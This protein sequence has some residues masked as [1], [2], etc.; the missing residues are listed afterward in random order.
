[1][2]CDVCGVDGVSVHLI[3]VIDG[4][5]REVHL[6][7]A[8]ADQRGLIIDPSALG[9]AT[10]LEEI[11]PAAVSDLLNTIKKVATPDL[12]CESC[13]HTFADFQQQNRLGCPEDY[14]VFRSILVGLIDKIQKTGGSPKHVGRVSERALARRSRQRRI[15]ALKTDLSAAIAEERFERAAELSDQLECL[16]KPDGQGHETR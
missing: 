14:Q 7:G 10:K 15:D 4:K 16:Q 1:M 13:G 2:G 11:L 5:K 9:V 8:C 12:L 3:E 6:C